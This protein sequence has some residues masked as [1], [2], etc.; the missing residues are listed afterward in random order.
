MN[1][2]DNVERRDSGP[3]HLD[4]TAGASCCNSDLYDLLVNKACQAIRAMPIRMVTGEYIAQILAT[5]SCKATEAGMDRESDV[6]GCAYIEV[7]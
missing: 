4:K 7:Q 5:L 3:A 2:L 6:L 1:A